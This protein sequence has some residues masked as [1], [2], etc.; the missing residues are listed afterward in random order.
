MELSW[1]FPDEGFVKVNV[2]AFTLVEPLPNGNDS[3]IGIVIRDKSGAIV[4]MVSGTI[5]NLTVRAN[6]LYVG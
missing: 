6:E 4:K 1:D 2:H 5:Q 3:G